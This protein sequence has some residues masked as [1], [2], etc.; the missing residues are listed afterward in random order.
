MKFALD[1]QELTP[2]DAAGGRIPLSVTLVAG[3]VWVRAGAGWRLAVGR[4]AA[5]SEQ[6]LDDPGRAR[7]LR[8]ANGHA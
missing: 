6:V 3:A 1:P 4:T 8:R 5:V 2:V 7:A